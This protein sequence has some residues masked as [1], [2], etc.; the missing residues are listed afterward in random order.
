[1]IQV[2]QVKLESYLFSEKQCWPA[3]G[4]FLKPIALW[5]PWLCPWF[6]SKYCTTG[7]QRRNK[8]GTKINRYFYF[9]HIPSISGHAPFI[10]MHKSSC[11]AVFFGKSVF[12]GQFSRDKNRFFFQGIQVFW[13]KKFIIVP[14]CLRFQQSILN[15]SASQRKTHLRTPFF[16]RTAP[17]GCFRW[18]QRIEVF[19]GEK[20]FLKIAV[21]KCSQNSW[22]IPMKKFIYSNIACHKSTTLLKM[23]FF[24]GIFRG[25]LLQIA[26]HVFSRAPLSRCFWH[27]IL[28]RIQSYI[29][30]G[31]WSTWYSKIV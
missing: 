3:E 16:S 19:W 20:V 22:T 5:I 14:M 1:M 12:S 11:L 6:H 13:C 17:S 26:E 8:G 24:I 7:Y 23:N 29:S 4:E 25:F 2:H 31:L 30:R 27:F 21:L 10:I 28:G 9:S 18:K 15:T